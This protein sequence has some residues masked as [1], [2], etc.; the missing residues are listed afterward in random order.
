MANDLSLLLYAIV[1]Q[2]VAGLEAVIVTAK[3]VTMQRQVPAAADLGLPHMGHFVN[4]KPLKAN[5][6]AAEVLAIPRR[7]R[8]EMNVPAR[9]HDNCC[10]LQGEPAP[11]FQRHTGCI[12]CAAEHGPDQRSFSISQRARASG[13]TRMETLVFVQ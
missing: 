9:G 5:G 1:L 10:R 7:F 11:P 6:G 12:D 3:G 2:G 13:R 8:V 4:E